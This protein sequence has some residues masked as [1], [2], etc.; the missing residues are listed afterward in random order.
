MITKFILMD[1]SSDGGEDI[2]GI[3]SS[4]ADAEEAFY[5]FCADWVYKIMMTEAPLNVFGKPEWNWA[6]D[7]KYLM[8]ECARVLIIM[9]APYY[10]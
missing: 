2:H 7:Y 3:Y 5:E 8:K 1:Y 4:R 10:E 9:E 6:N